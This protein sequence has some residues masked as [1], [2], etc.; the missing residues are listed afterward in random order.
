MSTPNDFLKRTNVEELVRPPVVD[1]ELPQP[2]IE[3]TT[4]EPFRLP[5]NTTDPFQSQ[6]YAADMA[7]GLSN[8]Q[9]K[10]P[11]VVA[12]W[13][14]LAIPAIAY[15]FFHIFQFF[16]SGHWRSV[17]TPGE[18]AATIGALVVLTAF[19]GLWPYLLL[20]RGAAKR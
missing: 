6:H 16:N 7:A 3:D 4:R 14:F 12:A 19:C 17:D 18:L 2:A 5:Y 1:P 13:I 15:W 9:L 8:P 11:I 20:R 10:T